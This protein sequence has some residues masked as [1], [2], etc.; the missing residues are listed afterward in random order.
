MTTKIPIEEIQQDV[1]RALE[2]DIG[3]G[4]LTAN[5]IP[6][7]SQGEASVISREDAV[8]CGLAWF[9]QSFQLL[10]SE[11]NIQWQVVD[12]EQVKANQIL[13]TL[14]GPSRALLSGE[15]TALNFLQT[16]SA[17]A[18]LTRR[19][20]DA[21]AA[22]KVQILDTRKTIPG[23]RQAQ[24]Y[25]VRCGGGHN[26]RMGL[27]DAIL[28]KENHITAAGSIAAAITKAHALIKGAT[29]SQSAIV[30]VEVEDLPQL[31]EALTTGVDVVLLDNM[32]NDTL[33]EAVTLTRGRAKLEAS[34]GVNLET[35]KAIAE[36][37]VDYI[38]V[39]ALTKDIQATDL[40]MRF[41][42][43]A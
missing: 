25:A 17:T 6:E 21:V 9:E 18:S 24:K 22:S 10:D 40:S 36:T 15:R 28:I 34:G 32:T 19:Y 4:D 41:N 35:I 30:E 27:Y 31:N 33:R 3:S 42:G 20:V 12:G 38:S 11:V 16:L 2:E 23:L 26:H 43:Q 7:N 39:G 13:C 37:G 5:L 8:I 29:S 1:R 14:H